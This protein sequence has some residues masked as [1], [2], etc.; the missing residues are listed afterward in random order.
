MCAE[1]RA[2]AK[3]GFASNN[4]RAQGTFS[5]VVIGG[6]VR[7]GKPENQAI[8]MF[9]DALGK[10]LAVGIVP[11]EL[12]KGKQVRAHL[13]VDSVAAGR[14]SLNLLQ[15]QAHSQKKVMQLSMETNAV[16]IRV[17]RGSPLGQL[18]RVTQQM[19]PAF[20]FFNLQWGIG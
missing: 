5:G 10:T 15:S 3:R 1:A 6:N 20:G 19:R 16:R 18:V 8:K 14:V 12:G 7:T 9:E 17:R 4:S 2:T 13:V 11:R